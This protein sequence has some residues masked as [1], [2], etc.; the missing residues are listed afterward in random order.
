[1]TD[2]SAKILL[3]PKGNPLTREALPADIRDATSF[4]VV[5]DGSADFQ[6]VHDARQIARRCMTLGEAVAKISV[7]RGDIK[8]TIRMPVPRVQPWKELPALLIGERPPPG[9]VVHVS[10][11]ERANLLQLFEAIA[12]LAVEYPETF[13][14][15]TGGTWFSDVRRNLYNANVRPDPYDESENEADFS[16]YALSDDILAMPR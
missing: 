4:I 6:M 15:V 1:M 7:R 12:T 14:R 11:K 9:C 10:P 13:E 5:Q 2:D 8:M 16:A 3:P